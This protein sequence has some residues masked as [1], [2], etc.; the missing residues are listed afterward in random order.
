MKIFK[1][2][3]SKSEKFKPDSALRQIESLEIDRKEDLDKFSNWMRGVSK[4]TSDLPDKKELDKLNE[5]VTKGSGKGMGILGAVAALAGGG[6]AFG[7]LGGMDGISSMVGGAMSF[8][9][10]GVSTSTGSGTNI[11]GL[12]NIQRIH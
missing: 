8:I 4:E 9:T 5:E 7:A 6:L 10:G 11:L 1:Q 3:P 12:G 2:D